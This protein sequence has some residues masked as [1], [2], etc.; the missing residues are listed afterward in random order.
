MSCLSLKHAVS[1]LIHYPGNIKITLNDIVRYQ[2]IIEIQYRGWTL[3]LYLVS[4]QQPSIVVI[5]F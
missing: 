4:K 3:I 5:V 2:N 1:F